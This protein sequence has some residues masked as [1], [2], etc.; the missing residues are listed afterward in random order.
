MIR[1]ILIAAVS[2]A[3]LA[4]QGCTNTT[5]YG[6][7]T[8][9]QTEKVD[10]DS[11]ALQQAAITM[12]SQL[13]NDP[14]IIKAGL[15]KRP[16]LAVFGV[17]D[18]TGDNIDLAQINSNILSTFNKANRFRFVSAE[19]VIRENNRLNPDLYDLVEKA[20]TADGMGDALDAD[21]LIVGDIS[22]VITRQPTLKQVHYRLK[23]KALDTAKGDF[24]WQQSQEM[25]VSEKDIVYGI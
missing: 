11:F 12:S 8:A 9:P 21:F 20:E 25:L 23:L 19:D 13:I 10:L 6:I 3:A 14:E 5:D 22:K 17:I 18:F 4:M 15:G 7:A 2:M 16:V 24:V 1:K